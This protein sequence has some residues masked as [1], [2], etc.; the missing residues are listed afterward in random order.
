MSLEKINPIRDNQ[1]YYVYVL[2]SQKDRHWHAGSTRDR[3]AFKLIYL[4]G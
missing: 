4:M 1:M 2:Q 3:G